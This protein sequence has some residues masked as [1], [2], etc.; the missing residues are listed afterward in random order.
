[1]NEQLREITEELLSEL[2]Q[3]KIKLGRI[4][5]FNADAVK[6]SYVVITNTVKMIE[7]Y[8]EDLEDFNGEGKREVAVAMLNE[9]I[10]IP[11]LPE[12]VEG[13]LLGWSVDLAVDLFNRLG[14]QVWIDVFFGEEDEVVQE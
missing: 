6:D 10:D 4:G 11:F 13:A 14:G 1:M 8:A 2:N 9:V 5:K 12:F 7:I 3:K